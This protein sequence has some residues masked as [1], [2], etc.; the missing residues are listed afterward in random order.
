MNILNYHLI[1][2]K[3][4]VERKHHVN[5]IINELNVPINIFHGI[6]VEN[7]FSNHEEILDFF[8]IYDPLFR[9]CRGLPKIKG[10]IGCYLSH[11][12]LIKQISENLNSKYSV[13]FEDD[14]YLTT[15]T[16]NDIKQII[17]KIEK[18]N[19]D[20]DI[21]YLRN[22]SDNHGEIITDNIYKFDK[23]NTCF[24]TCALLINNKYIQKIYNSNLD[25]H[26]EIDTQYVKY[27]NLNILTIYPCLLRVNYN[28][29]SN[30]RPW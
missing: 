6:Y 3:E 4:H 11:H 7:D 28:L 12:L 9:T 20:F 1:H 18:T 2:C 29:N 27:G 10:A 8:K 26:A 5:N 16:D 15:Q 30:I 17:F 22:S 14:I 24:Q 25:A 13:I 23:K 19:T 21:C